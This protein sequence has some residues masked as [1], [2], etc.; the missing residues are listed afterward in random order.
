MSRR[1]ILP[2]AV[3][4][5]LPLLA[6]APVSPA[7]ANPHPFNAYDLVTMDLV[8]D[9]QVS[10][11]GQWVAF[12]V[13]TT[14]LDADR[15]RTD[16]WR[17]KTDGGAPQRLTTDPASDGSPRW[18][19]GG[20]S[21]YFLSSRSGSSQVW[22]LPLGGGEA[23]Q[24]TDLPLD[25]GGYLLSPDGTHLAVTLDVLPDCDTPQ[26]TS[27][28]LAAQEESNQNAHVYDQLFVRH[29]DTWGDGR[30]S[31]LFVVPADGGGEAVDVTRGLDADVPSKPFGGAEE[32]AF[33]PDGKGL[34]YTARVVGAFET[35]RRYI[36][37]CEE[38][39]GGRRERAA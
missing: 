31:H 5:A 13:R 14:D 15:G 11:D 6:L 9:P 18:A 2:V 23:V 3:C 33:T 21:L 29:W 32:I 25:V 10:P 17:V 28:R 24:V 38:R 12:V 34:V 4:A 27:D 35:Y 37:E 8:S 7:H 1:F 16:L 30:R 26:C 36:Q 20:T 22:R 39:G 19:P